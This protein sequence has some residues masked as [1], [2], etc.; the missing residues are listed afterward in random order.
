MEPASISGEQWVA[1]VSGEALDLAQ[2][3]QFVEDPGA[4]AISTFSGVTRNSFKGKAVVKLEYECYTD[5]ALKKLKDVC[6][7]CCQKHAII[8]LAVAHRVGEVWV[9]QPSVLIAA[10]SAHRLEAIQACH[11]VIDAL[12]ATVP[13]W[14]KEFF[15]DGS[16]WKE[17]AE[18]QLLGNSSEKL[19]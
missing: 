13:I 10:S 14:K 1:R 3:M 4:G 17:N 16:V 9:G 8:R 19:A 15:E 12:K 5:M 7:E 6:E 11:W 2:C 18:C